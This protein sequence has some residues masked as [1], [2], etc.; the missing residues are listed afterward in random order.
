M[1]QEINKE[2]EQLDFSRPILPLAPTTKQEK[3]FSLPS[4]PAAD[5]GME[6]LGQRDDKTL[7]EY[8]VRKN[9][10]RHSKAFDVKTVQGLPDGRQ[11][12]KDHNGNKI[13]IQIDDINKLAKGNTP[14]KTLY[15]FAL[16][17]AN[18]QALNNGQ[19]VKNKVTFSIQELVDLGC[20]KNKDTARK[21][22]RKGKEI[23]TSLKL[24]G[25]FV[26][27]KDDII[28]DTLQVLFT[29]ADEI[30]GNECALYLN[31]NLNWEFIA[32][33]FTVIP[34][35]YFALPIRAKELLYYVCFRAR[36]ELSNLKTKGY[37]DIS[38]RSI[39]Q[40]LNLPNEEGN[41][42]PQRT[43]KEPILEAVNN[44]EEMY[45]EYNKKNS[46]NV[47][48]PELS[49]LV[50]HN[51]QPIDAIEQYDGKRT[52]SIKEF[53][54]E[55]HLRVSLAGEY[56]TP[57]LKIYTDQQKQIKAA[58]TRQEKLIDHAKAINL[59]KSMDASKKKAD[60]KE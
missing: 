4:S 28:V 24:R 47:D 26:K 36:Q 35:W 55:C 44:I 9:A 41:A 7:A 11:I 43:I 40:R 49:F 39:Q 10:L 45:N 19:L 60:R 1:R 12:I 20:Y 25:K 22:Y 52:L 29:G 57:L 31:P 54:D 53:L 51:K 16:K 58:Q 18:E 48:T 3:L 46:Y 56:L 13:I 21:A 33:F 8:A 59:A 50:M 34:S 6:I 5:M 30:K 14:A 23:L 2:V 32:A 42:N 37:F 38:F 17:K 27:G 15:V